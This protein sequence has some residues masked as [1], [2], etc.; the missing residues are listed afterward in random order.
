MVHRHRCRRAKSPGFTG[1]RTFFVLITSLWV[2]LASTKFPAVVA[3]PSPGFAEA[4]GI[5]RC[6]PADTS[7]A[8]SSDSS[9]SLPR[10]CRICCRRTASRR[11]CQT[12][13]AGYVTSMSSENSWTLM[14]F[15]RA[16]QPFAPAASGAGAM[17][18]SSLCRRLAGRPMSLAGLVPR[19]ST[20]E[21]IAQ[22]RRTAMLLWK[23]MTPRFAMVRTCGMT[24]K[25]KRK[26]SAMS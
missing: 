6:S 8:G 25:R 4:S 19:G 5:G 20:A 7:P 12:M 16:C 23:K 11:S 24:R 18:R 17:V 13:S 2:R 22:S 15:V 9:R 14:S 3:Y 10:R 26:T 1:R 21:R